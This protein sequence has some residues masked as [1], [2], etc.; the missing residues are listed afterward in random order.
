MFLVIIVLIVENE[1][2]ALLL[3]KCENAT[4]T[5]NATNSNHTTSSFN[6]EIA[7]FIQH[8]Q[9]DGKPFLSDDPDVDAMVSINYFNGI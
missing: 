1:Y 9:R 3:E 8:Q 4:A 2:I 5:L 7:A 6:S